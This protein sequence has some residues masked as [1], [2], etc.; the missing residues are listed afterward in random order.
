MSIQIKNDDKKI[1]ITGNKGFKLELMVEKNSFKGIGRVWV[2]NQ[3]LRSGNIPW[4]PFFQTPEGILYKSFK[5]EDIVVINNDRFDIKLTAGGE[6]GPYQEWYCSHQRPLFNYDNIAGSDDIYPDDLIGHFELISENI[7]GH[8][9]TGFRYSYSF[10]SKTRKIYSLLDQATW[11]LT[12][13][14]H[15]SRVVMVNGYTK[16][17]GEYD[18]STD[19]P[20]STACIKSK[21]IDYDQGHSGLHSICKTDFQFGGRYSRLQSFDFQYTDQA[22]FLGYW[23]KP[24]PLK[25]F[26]I[27]NNHELLHFDEYSFPLTNNVTTVWKHILVDTGRYDVTGRRNQWTDIYEAIRKRALN[28]YKI[29]DSLRLPW[30]FFEPYMEDDHFEE[31][32]PFFHDKAVKNLLPRLADMGYKLI[33]TGPYL[34]DSMQTRFQVLDEAMRK[35]FKLTKKSFWW[36]HGCS[37]LDYRF[38]GINGDEMR[39]LVTAAHELKMKVITWFSSHIGILSPLL[40]EHL[41]W[42]VRTANGKFETSVYQNL[43][44]ALRLD[45]KNCR[46]WLFN[47]SKIMRQQTGLDGFFWD[48][49]SDVALE[50][51]HWDEAEKII[52]PLFDDNIKFLKLLRDDDCEMILEGVTPF[53]NYNTSPWNMESFRNCDYLVYNASCKF[54]WS[55]YNSELY[56]RYLALG[57]R[58]LI[59]ICPGLTNSELDKYSSVVRQANL[60]YNSVISWIKKRE[61]LNNDCGVIWW[62]ESKQKAA[63]FSFIEFPFT[64][65]DLKTVY[66]I[67]MGKL[68][69]TNKN[70]FIS[71]PQ[72]TYVL[73]FL[74]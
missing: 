13:D 55:E 20:F 52:K 49:F 18:G 4:R 42:G 34:L 45:L 56:Y 11:E 57:F 7:A 23:E 37:I 38:P 3:L 31:Y 2:A 33:A 72:H 50:K 39:R 25:S 64:M 70:K 68:I 46:D 41:D 19:R 59:K 69:S 8:D 62:D 51:I 10:T 32:T 17:T 5:L 15:N 26:L 74:K 40:Y 43:L 16:G 28:T 73:T 35:D 71:L 30:V 1:I 27:R 36:H 21:P 22:A 54:P 9:F 63:L 29:K 14:I 12:G 53:G 61:L 58:A 47:R 48:S 24:N 44:A 65:P 60:D 67:T 6:S 66:D